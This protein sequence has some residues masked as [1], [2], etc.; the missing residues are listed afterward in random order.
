[1]KFNDTTDIAIV[2]GDRNGD[3]RADFQIE[4]QSVAALAA[5]DFIL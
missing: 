5:A 1:M 3:G 4:V 2:S